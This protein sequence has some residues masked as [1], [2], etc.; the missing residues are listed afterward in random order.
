MSIGRA[1]Q[2]GGVGAAFA[3]FLTGFVVLVLGKLP[4]SIAALLTTIDILIGGLLFRA[5]SR[6]IRREK[7]QRECAAQAIAFANLE[8]G[9]KEQKHG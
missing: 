3:G 2:Y 6:Q 5:G 9:Q 4:P 8:Q 7:N 1:K